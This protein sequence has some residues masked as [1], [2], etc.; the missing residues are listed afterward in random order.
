LYS[1][2]KKQVMPKTHSQKQMNYDTSEDQNN[3]IS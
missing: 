2:L 3:N 1:K